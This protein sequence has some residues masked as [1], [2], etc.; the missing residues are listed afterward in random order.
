MEKVYLRRI[1]ATFRRTQSLAGRVHAKM[2]R[3]MASP[4]SSLKHCPDLLV[5]VLTNIL[6]SRP[7]LDRL[8]GDIQAWRT[9]PLSPSMQCLHRQMAALTRDEYDELM[10]LF[11]RTVGQT[12]IVPLRPSQK[13]RTVT[14][15]APPLLAKQLVHISLRKLASTKIKLGHQ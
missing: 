9:L 8:S 11:N 2:S 4:T 7:I 12:F 14:F 5:P 13:F 6:A 15:A 10:R 1:T 3:Y